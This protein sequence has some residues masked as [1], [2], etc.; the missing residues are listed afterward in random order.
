MQVRRFRGIA[1]RQYPVHLAHLT[2]LLTVFLLVTGGWAPAW[3]LAAFG[4]LALRAWILV[5][6]APLP[7][8]TIG[9]SEMLFGLA[10]ILAAGMGY[11]LM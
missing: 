4:M 3:V 2:A 11:R 8:K 9:W 10:T 5:A 1:V 7:A 6:R